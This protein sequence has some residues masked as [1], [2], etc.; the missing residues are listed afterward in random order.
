[1]G[2]DNAETNAVVA[3]YWEIRNGWRRFVQGVA[4]GVDT[5]ELIG[6]PKGKLF[7]RE[8]V[9]TKPSMWRR[10]YELR[11]DDERAAVMRFTNWFS[12]EAIVQGLGAS[13]SFNRKGFF[14]QS[15][16]AENLDLGEKSAPF[17]YSWSGGGNL[18]L[19]DG[20]TLTFRHSPWRAK[21]FWETSDHQALVTFMRRSW[22]RTDM[23]V[24]LE[25]L[26]ADY[27]ELPFLILF[28]YYLRV[29]YEEDAG[30][31]AVM[32]SG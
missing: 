23:G 24:T 15:A 28:G 10:E 7:G 12:R 14:R 17:R 9:W 19:D 30:S 21:S 1:M 11:I 13:F 29:L 31:S 25:P 4:M 26:A 16:T 8:I 32:V 20:L 22:W 5:E 27:P 3:A 18:V 6:K 2:G